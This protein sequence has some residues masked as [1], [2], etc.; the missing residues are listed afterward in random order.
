MLRQAGP[1]ETG[2]GKV[3]GVIAFTLAVMCLLGNYMH[4][5]EGFLKQQLFPFTRKG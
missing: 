4:M 3:T 2:R 5:P 1:L